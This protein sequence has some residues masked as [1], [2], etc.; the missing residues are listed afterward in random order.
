MN[1][2]FLLKKNLYKCMPSN[3]KSNLNKTFNTIVLK[4]KKVTL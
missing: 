1:T 3:N 4:Y 2:E